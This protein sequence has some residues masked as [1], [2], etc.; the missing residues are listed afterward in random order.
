MGKG[1]P[2]T[3]RGKIFRHSYGKYRARKSEVIVSGF[4]EANDTVETIEK[5]VAEP[6]AQK[7][8][9]EDKPKK[10]PAKKAPAKKATKSEE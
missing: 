5:V 10:A 3:K 8:V 4:A 1:D 9:S 2:R 6:K 7:V